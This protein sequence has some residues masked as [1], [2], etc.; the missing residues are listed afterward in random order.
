MNISLHH[1]RLIETISK[2]GTLTKSALTL[3]L[4]Q[5]ALS[6]Q[7]KELERIMGTEMFTRQGKMMQL[8][9]NGTRFLQSA[10]K[11]LAEI[12][13]LE[14]DISNFKSGK[15]G[16]LNISTQSYTA[17]HW[18][19]GIIKSFNCVSPDTNIHILSEASKRPLEY[20]LRG[21]LDVAIVRTQMTNAKITYV[22]VILDRLM[23]VMCKDNEL[24]KKSVFEIADFGNTELI[25]PSYDASY[26]DTPLIEHMIQAH[27]IKLKNHHRIH[28]TDTT[29]N[30]VEANLGIGIM[31]DWIV[32]PYLRNH[33][34]VAIPVTPDI[35][36]RTWYAATIK[37]SPAIQN[38]VSC[39][40][41]YFGTYKN[42]TGRKT[43]ETEIFKRD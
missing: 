13:S 25:M 30:M 2:E 23:V 7:L 21:D 34:I 4:T 26:Q 27:H 12:K 19:P 14:E 40:K 35:D 1:F 9:E 24:A 10:E 43:K 20:L 31:P 16:K 32:K 11:I 37:D 5:S 17:Y 18:L 38:F 8:T 39:L 41:E 33:N 36:R 3:H 29:I 28:Y 42:E 15:T 22:P 6:H